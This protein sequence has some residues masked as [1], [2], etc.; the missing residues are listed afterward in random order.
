MKR[1]KDAY[2]FLV[3]SFAI[4]S[5]VVDYGRQIAWCNDLYSDIYGTIT[6][7]TTCFRAG[8]IL[9]PF[10][11]NNNLLADIENLA[12]YADRLD[13]I[14]KVLIECSTIDDQETIYRKVRDAF[15]NSMSSTASR[16]LGIDSQKT[17]EAIIKALM[18]NR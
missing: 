10:D 8:K 15:E 4:E 6:Y 13:K 14:N 9:D 1:I 18:E 2:N 12:W 17:A 7:L 5:A 3:P 16:I 11:K